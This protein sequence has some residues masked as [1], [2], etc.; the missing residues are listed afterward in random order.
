MGTLFRPVPGCR[1]PRRGFTLVELMVVVAVVVVLLASA[2]PA[3]S[4][5]ATA[6]QI[7][8]AKSTFAGALALAR[9]EAAKRGTSVI[10]QARGSAPSGNE[11][12]A[13]WDVV[14]DTNGN[15]SVDTSDLTVR[16]FDALPSGVKL[17]GAATIVYRATGYLATATDKTYTVCRASGSHDGFQVTVTA[18]GV[19]DILAINSCS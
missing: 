15:G 19:T 13:G 17:S 18:S 11:F 8:A 1:Q 9:S 10:V 2:G 12:G 7:A 4:S 5:F 6:N 3:M 14:V 16:S